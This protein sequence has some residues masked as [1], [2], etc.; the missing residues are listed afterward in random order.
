MLPGK[1]DVYGWLSQNFKAG[2]KHNFTNSQFLNEL[3]LDNHTRHVRKVN[4]WKAEIYLLNDVSQQKL[5]TESY[6]I[7]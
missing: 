7:T 1:E 4:V 3:V 5:I 6:F 2:Y